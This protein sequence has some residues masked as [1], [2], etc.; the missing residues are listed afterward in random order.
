MKSMFN[1]FMRH[2]VRATED[3]LAAQP[4]TTRDLWREVSWTSHQEIAPALGSG[5]VDPALTMARVLANDPSWGEIPIFSLGTLARSGV[6]AGLRFALLHDAE[7][8][9]EVKLLRGA[10]AMLHGMDEARKMADVIGSTENHDQAVARRKNLEA[11]L[12]AAGIV[13]EG[14][15]KGLRLIC[16][17]LGLKEPAEPNL[18]TAA[19]V[20]VPEF[21]SA[22]K[23]GSLYAHTEYWAMGEFLKE[24]DRRLV[25]RLHHK[26]VVNSV[27]QILA[28]MRL[29][30][31]GVVPCDKE[32]FQRRT[33]ASMDQV[34]LAGQALDAYPV[35]P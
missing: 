27:I 10:G 21:L 30:S 13:V 28:A 12:T 2:P 35:S 19:E 18:T 33:I 5:V 25:P 4:E 32:E 7:L 24:E 6:E 8:N 34:Y 9:V 17:T 26:T 14:R 20:L 29:M 3:W 11:R 15:N 22:Y 23:W 16:P 1:H 31:S